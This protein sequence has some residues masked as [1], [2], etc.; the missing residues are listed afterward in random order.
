VGTDADGGDSVPKVVV[1]PS[2]TVVKSSTLGM[3]A[4]TKN[5]QSSVGQHLSLN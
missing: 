2:S 3:M 1:I 4:C 5:P